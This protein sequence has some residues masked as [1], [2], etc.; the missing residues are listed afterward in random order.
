MFDNKQ[1]LWRVLLC[2]LLLLNFSCKNK[3]V[4]EK[5]KVLQPPQENIYNLSDKPEIAELKRVSVSLE[6][7]EVSKR[8][9][10]NSNY[11]QHFITLTFPFPFNVNRIFTTKGDTVKKGDKLFEISSDELNVAISEYKKRGDENLAQSIKSAGLSPDS[12]LPITR[13][14]IVSPID[15]FI[16]Q[17]KVEEQKSYSSQELAVIQA[18]GELLLE[19]TLPLNEYSD[20]M[21]FSVLLEKDRELPA[22]VIEANVS[23]TLA[24][25]RLSAQMPLTEINSDKI[26][27]KAS[28]TVRNVF[29]IDKSALW[30]SDN[31]YWLFI[32]KGDGLIEKREVKGFYDNDTFVVTEGLFENERIFTEGLNVI[33]KYIR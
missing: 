23:G 18:K 15:G 2:L 17:I 14:N 24:K 26:V 4:I 6:G 30:T 22:N 21:T 7:I 29:R 9:R 27:I 31:K 11:R 8:Y 25:I 13:I 3:E 10:F 20:D 28:K 16:T 32:D 19:G 12:P 33:R 5:Q 1:M